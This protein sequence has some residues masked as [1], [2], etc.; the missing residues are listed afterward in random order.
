MATATPVNC[1]LRGL[2]ATL[3]FNLGD[4]DTPIWTEHL[5]ITGDMTCSETE[6]DNE[7]TTR[8]RNR[9][10]KEYSEGDTDINITGTQVMDSLYIGWQVLY[11]M[12]TH[13]EPYDIMYLSEPLSEVGAVGWRGMMRNKD[14]TGNAPATGPQTQNFSLR[15][16]AC[17]EV[18]VRPVRVSVADTAAD[19]DPT[20]VEAVES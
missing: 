19:Y 11:S 3:Y 14:R 4:E 13:G 16:A 10:V 15:P 7:L 18:P 9:A 8:N 1:D 17:T 5:G 12:R 6:D 2:D 20:E